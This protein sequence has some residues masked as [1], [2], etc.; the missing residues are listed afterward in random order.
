MRR[1]EKTLWAL[2]SADSPSVA[3]QAVAR[4]ASLRERQFVECRGKDGAWFEAYLVEKCRF[5][6]LV[7]REDGSIVAVGFEA[8]RPA[9]ELV[10]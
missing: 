2:S 7:A 4:W 3:E 9:A 10:H 8:V 1:V 6:A 5:G